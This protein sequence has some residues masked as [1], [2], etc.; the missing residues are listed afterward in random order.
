MKRMF[1][2]IQFI[3]SSPRSIVFVFIDGKKDGVFNPGKTTTETNVM[4]ANLYKN[5]TLL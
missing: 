4:P 1:K 3:R 2:F 5:G